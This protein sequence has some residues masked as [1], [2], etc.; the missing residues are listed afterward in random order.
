MGWCSVLTPGPNLK[1]LHLNISFALDHFGIHLQQ[2]PEVGSAPMTEESAVRHL[3]MEW[4]D[5]SL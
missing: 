3:N 5:L 1:P 4:V 2:V